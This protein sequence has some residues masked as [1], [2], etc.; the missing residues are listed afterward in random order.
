MTIQ[1]FSKRGLCRVAVPGINLF[2]MGTYWMD[3]FGLSDVPI[4][5]SDVYLQVEVDP[6]FQNLPTIKTHKELCQYIRLT[7]GINSAPGAYQL[8]LMDTMLW[9][10]SSTCGYLDVGGQTQEEHEHNHHRALSRLQNENREEQLF[11]APNQVP[12]PNHGRRRN[13]V[14]FNQNI[15][16]CQHNPSARRSY[17][18]LVSRGRELLIQVCF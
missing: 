1:G 10:L 4:S 15:R 16:R 18:T 8:Q 3:N 13:S 12:G 9:G 5:H 6:D 17:T 2:V 14:R 11:D 7:P